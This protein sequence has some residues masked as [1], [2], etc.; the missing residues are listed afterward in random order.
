MRGGKTVTWLRRSDGEGVQGLS[1]RTGVDDIGEVADPI[2]LAVLGRTPVA[3]ARV[4]GAELHPVLVLN[5][6]CDD[7]VPD[8]DHASAQAGDHRRV[9]HHGGRY[10]LPG[11]YGRRS[12]RATIQ[13]D[14]TPNDPSEELTPP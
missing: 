13:C 2:V 7:G 1:H 12:Q 14:G 5:L 9:R 8:V 11:G 3:L 4:D 10:R 6:A